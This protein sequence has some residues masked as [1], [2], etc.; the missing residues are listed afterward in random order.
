MSQTKLTINP[1][2]E[3][4][5]NNFTTRITKGFFNI[6]FWIDEFDIFQ[7]IFEKNL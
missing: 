5:S 2:T 6:D 4:P 3:F 1:N 7:G